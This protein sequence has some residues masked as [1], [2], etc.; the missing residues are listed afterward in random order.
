MKLIPLNNSV[1][2]LPIVQQVQENALFCSQ[3]N[4]GE[5]QLAIVES[6]LDPNLKKGAKVIFFKYCACPYNIGANK[7]LIVNQNDI[8]AKLEEE[9]E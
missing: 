8:I 6:A 3:N 1:I 9:N 7:Y 4:M 2:V 5:V